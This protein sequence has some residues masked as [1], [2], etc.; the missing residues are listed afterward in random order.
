MTEELLEKLDDAIG[1]PAKP[2]KYFKTKEEIQRRLEA[3]D[4]YNKYCHLSKELKHLEAGV[5]K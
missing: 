4:W 3:F 2:K 5:F 1:F